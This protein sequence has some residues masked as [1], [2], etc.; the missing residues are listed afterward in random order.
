MEKLI[1]KENIF[2]LMVFIFGFFVSLLVFPALVFAQSC[3]DRTT[4]SG[5][6][7]IFVGELADTGGDVINYVWFD[8]GKTTSYGQKTP[9][10][11]LTQQGI[12]CISVDNLEPCTTYHYRAAAR[13][14]AGTGYGEDKSFTTSC[15]LTVDI[16]ANGYDG[17]I[18]V[19]YNSSV[20]LTWNS[21]NA[22]YCSAFGDWSGSKAVSGSEFISN[23]ISSKTFTLS[24]SGPSGSASDSVTVNVGTQ[25]APTNIAV[26]KSVRN[27]S[28][29]TNYSNSVYADPG[30]VVSFSI[31]ITA[32]NS[33]INNLTVKDTLP[34]KLIFRQNTL[35]VD[36]VLISGDIISGLNIGSLFAN[37]KKTITF[38]A[39]VAGSDKFDFGETSLVNSV[40]VYAG[41][42]SGSDSVKVIVTKKAVAGATT[43]K[44]GLTNNIFLDSFLIP[45]LIAGL[46][47][48]IFK[49]RIIKWEEW[50]DEK[51]RDYEKYKSEKVLNSKIKKI[52]MKEV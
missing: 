13:N 1:R 23:L 51:K 50:L 49:A 21:S 26:K 3:P 14:S 7:V 16:K 45:L 46:I 22:N 18:S 20:T 43:I 38:E 17:P 52:R 42:S 24:C 10:K 28:D 48:W 6:S 11:T 29:G 15:G 27:L 4:V 12:Y 47:I 19:A 39:D 9:E 25:P 33:A 30:E 41:D 37:Q 5:T 2:F 44:T 35:K 40:M 32:G 36:G 8:Y 31:E 34:E